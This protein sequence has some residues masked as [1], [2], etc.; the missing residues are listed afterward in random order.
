MQS[1]FLENGGLF[2][3]FKNT[4]TISAVSIKTKLVMA[5]ILMVL[6]SMFF[7]SLAFYVVTSK[8]IE[9]RVTDYA[10]E[11]LEKT[12]ENLSTKLNQYENYLLQIISDKEI[13]NYITDESDGQN[14]DITEVPDYL[15]RDSMSQNAEIRNKIYKLF[16]TNS[17]FYAVTFLFSN[18]VIYT[19][20]LVHERTISNRKSYTDLLYAEE[21]RAVWFP[22]IDSRDMFASLHTPRRVI[23][24]GRSITNR[25]TGENIGIV[26]LTVHE[27]EIYSSYEKLDVFEGSYSFIVD[28]SDN[29]I[30]HSKR[31]KEL[32]END[33]EIIHSIE[34][35]LLGKIRKDI[36]GES[37]VILYQH[38]NIQDW[39]LISV[40]PSRYLYA[41]ITSI[42]SILALV[43]LFMI[44]A[45][46]ILS[47]LISKRISD[48]VKQLVVAMKEVEKGAMDVQ[49]ESNKQD[50]IGILTIQFNRM[51]L[52]INR[53]IERVYQEENQKY[54]AVYASLQAQI[55]P[56]FLFNT[57]NSIKLMLDMEYPHKEI[58]QITDS[59]IALLQA[60][61]SKKDAFITLDEELLNVQNYV[62]IQ[63]IR[64]GNMIE[65]K[66]NVSEDIKRTIIPKLILQPIVENSIIHGF[67]FSSQKGEILISTREENGEI[68]IYITDNGIG[69]DEEEIK[70]ILSEPPGNEKGKLNSIGIWN[71]HKRLQLIYGENYGVQ[72][73]SEKDRFTT[74]TISI[75]VKTT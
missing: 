60:V 30:S 22:S 65:L 72:I 75:P 13:Y 50:E 32:D 20:E 25:V 70:K 35:D 36:D 73:E 18:K 54:E 63:N 33:I 37:K 16:G 26:I 39:I 61:T 10:F 53:L 17:G 5:L 4:F 24:V 41:D 19:H 67:D 45:S 55:T 74:V 21:G 71:I 2:L 49:V 23:N 15:Y 34:S 29:M 8:T 44:I 51:L 69:I 38:M 66:I 58:L 62:I 6:F 56:H 12:D 28:G 57:L 42:M 52:E 43:F 11:V 64:Y 47:V 3:K 48:P 9:N 27:E 1:H 14:P 68:N 46:T 31:V 7:I 40:I 59:L